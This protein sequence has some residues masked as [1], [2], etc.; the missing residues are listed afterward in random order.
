MFLNLFIKIK[1][2]MAKKE[3]KTKAVKPKPKKEVKTTETKYH[4]VINLND[5]VFEL[6]TNDVASAIM[7]VAPQFLKTKLII[8]VTND[9]GRHAERVLYLQR[10]KL[11]FTNRYALEA[12]V[13]N[14]FV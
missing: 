11:L 5:Q 3:V 8:N 13:R 9:E 6:D 14:L 10:G 12:L 7:S 2:Y 1:N 4:V